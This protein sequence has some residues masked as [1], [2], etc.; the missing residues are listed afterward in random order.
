MGGDEIEAR[1]AADADRMQRSGARDASSVAAAILLLARVAWAETT[2]IAGASRGVGLELARAFATGGNSVVHATTR[3]RT[4]G[5]L[6]TIRGVHVHSL[7]VTNATQIA[8]IARGLNS[9]GDAIDLLLHNAGINNGSLERQMEVNAIAPFRLVDALMPAL[10]RSQHKRVCIIT[11]DRGQHY[12]VRRFQ[13][14]FNGKR[15]AKRCRDV[16][17]CSYAVSKGAAHETFRRLEPTWRARGITAVV[18]HPGGMATDMNGGLARCLAG[19]RKAKARGK[20][21]GGGTCVSAAMRAPEIRSVCSSLTPADAGKFLNWRRE[22][23]KW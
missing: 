14:R 9:G 17:Y 10:M 3:S 21:G 1:R 13:A 22:E 15:G 2:F 7:D 18:L 4:A 20:K 12:Y 6:G 16:P 23:M 8:G 5:E 11:S 19:M